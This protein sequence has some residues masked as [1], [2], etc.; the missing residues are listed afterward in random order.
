MSTK[1]TDPFKEVKENTNFYTM[2][3]PELG[4]KSDSLSFSKETKAESNAWSHE[5]GDQTIPPDQE[6]WWFE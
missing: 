6:C 5:F 4:V 1:H 3:Y 2:R